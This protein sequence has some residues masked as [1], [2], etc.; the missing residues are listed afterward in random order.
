MQRI[1][2]NL[3]ENRLYQLGR[4]FYNEPTF[5]A[6][7]MLTQLEM[8]KEPMRYDIINFIAKK[9]KA[10]YYL[11]IGVRN[12]D[13]NYNRINIKN[14][15]S[16][17][18]GVEFEADTIDF[19]ITSDDFFASLDKGSLRISAEIRF[20]II[21]IDGLHLAEQVDRDILNASKYLSENGFIILHDCSP[22]TEHHA[23]ETYQF[24]SGPAEG[25]WNGTTWKAYLKARTTYYSCCIDSDWGVGIL[26][27]Q[28]RGCFNLLPHNNNPFFEFHV[29]D[30]G[31]KEQLN[32]V[33]FSE[34][35]RSLH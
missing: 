7:R 27:K 29:L 30:R 17:D 33:S 25:F 18:P 10:N 12:P 23:R 21:F 20:D 16:V 15:F 35:S 31:R 2:K 34:F 9:T 1:I 26:S 14:K 19:K 32:L 24:D 3:N 8:S 28:N 5:A 22:P 13:D 11:E 6:V 4:R